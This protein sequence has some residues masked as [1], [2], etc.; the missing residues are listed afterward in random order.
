MLKLLLTCWGHSWASCPCYEPP[1]V[2]E[3]SNVQVLIYFGLLTV[4]EA[5]IL[6]FVSSSNIFTSG[7]RILSRFVYSSFVR[8]SCYDIQEKQHLT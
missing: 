4:F 2:F 7:S 6:N 5:I 8:A 1:F 3:K